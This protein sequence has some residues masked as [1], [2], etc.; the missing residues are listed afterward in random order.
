MSSKELVEVPLFP[1][2]SSPRVHKKKRV[3]PVRVPSSKSVVDCFPSASSTA[4]PSPP[5]PPVRVS[6]N[7][8]SRKSTRAHRPMCTKDISPPR[9]RVTFDLPVPTS[10]PIPPTTSSNLA[11]YCCDYR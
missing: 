1:S 8:L 5:A 2:E 7:P 9:K 4:L 11:F 3:L 10:S 6:R